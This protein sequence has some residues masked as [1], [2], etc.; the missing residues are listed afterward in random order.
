MLGR[1]L[2][3]AK[4][5]CDKSVVLIM[6]LLLAMGLVTLFSATYYP[7]TTAGD[8]LSAV[9][10]QLVGVAL[11]AAACASFDMFNDVEHRGRVFKEKVRSMV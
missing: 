3:K 5:A 11:G 7:R 6:L 1:I 9:K 8:P 10:K 4:R 2:P